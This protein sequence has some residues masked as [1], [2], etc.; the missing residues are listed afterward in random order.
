L[1][2]VEVQ[3]ISHDVSKYTVK[4]YDWYF[5]IVFLYI[6]FMRIIIVEV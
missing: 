2:I 4:N 5:I 1:I 6:F 3:K